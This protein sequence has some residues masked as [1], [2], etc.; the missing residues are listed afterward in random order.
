MK[1]NAAVVVGIKEEQPSVL[2]FAMLAARAH[3]AGLRVVHA[4]GMPAEPAG[5]FQGG[6]LVA[7]LRTAGT[8]VLEAARRVVEQE[9]PD[10]SAEYVL[11]TARTVEAL[12]DEA[13]RASMLVVGIDEISWPDRLLGGAV[14][15]HLAL[16]AACP[17][18]V[19]PE[20]V[21]PTPLSGGVVV[22]L[23]GESSAEGALRFAF[24]HA[25]ETTREL[26]VMHAVP[27]GTPSPAVE[28]A[29]AAIGEVIAGW[30]SSYPDVHVSTS[31]AHDQA[32][33]AC[34][35]ATEHAEL[36]VVG[37]PRRRGLAFAAARPVAAQVLRHA[38]CPVAVVPVDE[39]RPV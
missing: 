3:R 26:H 2:R 27:L 12:A 6:Q 25:A 16:G 15:T 28:S 14:A 30:A 37:R 10:L 17:V 7:D 1:T 22:T 36:V 4:S 20:R 8:A 5:P 31:F 34:I 38:H 23:D 35:R 19:V 18:V 9:D 32:D 29:R 13:R 33:D 39:P 24:E 21:S 11:R